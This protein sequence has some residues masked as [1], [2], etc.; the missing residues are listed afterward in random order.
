VR[1][2]G[3]KDWALEAYVQHLIVHGTLHL[4]GYDHESNEAEANAMETLERAACA[5]LGLADPYAE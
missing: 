3:E 4:L 5:R 1:E 2:A